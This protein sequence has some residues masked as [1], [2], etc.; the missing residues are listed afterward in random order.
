MSALKISCS[1]EK[2]ARFVI[3]SLAKT[4]A[5]LHSEFFRNSQLQKVQVI[6]RESGKDWTTVDPTLWDCTVDTIT[7]D[8]AVT[9]LK[10]ECNNIESHCKISRPICSES[11]SAFD[12]LMSARNRTFL[13]DKRLN[14]CASYSTRLFKQLHHNSIWL[15]HY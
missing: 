10:F 11:T 13:P 12:V 2:D 4:F 9:Q 7:Q 6:C 3:V 15:L 1:C 5:V 14:R 8:F